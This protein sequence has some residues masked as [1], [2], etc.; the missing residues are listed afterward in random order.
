MLISKEDLQNTIKIF[1]RYV[2]P[3]FRHFITIIVLMLMVAG[4]TAVYAFLVQKTLD[5]IFIEKNITMLVIIPFVIAG[6]TILKNGLLFLQMVAMGYFTIKIS[7][8]I[9]NDIYKKF[10][11]Q[12]MKDFNEQSSGAMAS[13]VIY[14]PENLTNGMNIIL[15]TAIRDFLTVL[16]LVGALLYQNPILTLLSFVAFPLTILPIVIISRKLRHATTT[17]Q[18]GLDYFLSKMD[19]ALKS[20]KLIKSYVAED[21]EIKRM[22]VI[23]NKLVDLRK[24][25]T[26]LGNIPS[27]LNETIGVIGIALVIWYGGYQ[28]IKG[29]ATAGTFFSFFIS[30]TL[31]YKPLKSLSNIGLTIQMFFQSCTRMFRVLEKVPSVRSKENAIVLDSNNNDY[32]ITFQN[33]SFEYS[34]EYPILSD[35]NFSVNNGTTVA[36][37]GPTGAGKSTIVSLLL[38]FYDVT[39]GSIKINGIDIKDIS[40]E[41][42]RSKM[43]FVSQEIQLLDDTVENNIRYNTENV[44][45][46]DIERAAKLA[47]AYEFIEKLPNKYQTMIG[48]SGTKLSGGQRQRIAIARAILR[49]TPILLLD[50][51]TSALDSISEKLIQDALEKFMVGKTTI[52]IAH[53]LST[54]RNADVILVIEN[55]KLTESGSHTQLIEQGGHYSKLY[56]TQFGIKGV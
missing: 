24:K 40:V 45:I 55:G 27:P 18:T 56:N 42:L 52:V 41:S 39:T 15:T 20:P 16:F 53:R 50:E 49:N 7:N 22:N 43:S 21:F 32:N 5:K 14:D 36:L 47:N 51:A 9:R 6:V 48:Q 8:S 35:V 28:V 33:V 30:M 4:L 31:A 2:A 19:D 25:M 10:I 44:T 37:V 3:N 34:E 23:L 17:N 26:R 1:K 12:D 54:I 11:Y 29:T 38:R 13:S 46:E